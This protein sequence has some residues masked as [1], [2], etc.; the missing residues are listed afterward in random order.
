MNSLGS[1][2]TEMFRPCAKSR[3]MSRKF[4]RMSPRKPKSNQNPKKHLLLIISLSEKIIGWKLLETQKVNLYRSLFSV[5][6]LKA[7][8]LFSRDRIHLQVHIHVSIHI[9]LF[10]YSIITF[11]GYICVGSESVSVLLL[12]SLKFTF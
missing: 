2:E 11:A 10:P 5:S 1:R 8:G 7:R 4:D 3:P 6:N 12:T 9:F